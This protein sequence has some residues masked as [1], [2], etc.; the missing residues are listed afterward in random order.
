MTDITNT[1]L[2]VQ[3]DIG[4]DLFGDIAESPAESDD[5]FADW[6]RPEALAANDLFGD[7]PPLLE[8]VVEVAPAPMPD[9]DTAIAFLRSLRP[10]GIHQLVALRP[11]AVEGKKNQECLTV[12]LKGNE[13]H[14]RDFILAWHSKGWGVYYST[15]AVKAG[16]YKKAAKVDV[17]Q[18][19]G[20]YCDIDPEP[21]EGN[22]DPVAH[23]AEERVRLLAKAEAMARDAVAPPTFVVDSGGGIQATWLLDTPVEA[24]PDN[25]VLLEAHGSGLAQKL[26]E[27][28]YCA[29]KVQDVNRLLRLPGSIN[30]PK[31]KKRLQ[32]Q[33]PAL[34]RLLHAGGRRYTVEELALIAPAIDA[35]RLRRASG[36]ASIPAGSASI[37]VLPGLLAK[38][39][40]KYRDERAE[41]IKVLFACKF[42]WGDEAWEAFDEWSSESPNYDLEQNRMTWER[43]HPRGDVHYGSLAY[44]AREGEPVATAGE[45]FE[46]IASPELDMIDAEAES[47]KVPPP[48][49]LPTFAELLERAKAMTSDTSGE[50]RRAL[51]RDAARLDLGSVETDD[52]I[53]AV[54]AATGK[55]VTPLRKE[56]DG[57]RSALRAAHRAEKIEKSG[58]QWWAEWVYVMHD[59]RFHRR[60]GSSVERSAFNLRFGSKVPWEPGQRPPSADEYFCNGHTDLIADEVRYRPGESRFFWEDGKRLFNLYRA[61]GII[62]AA[63][64][65]GPFLRN[66][67]HLFADDPGALEWLLGWVA[68]IMTHPGRKV[69]SAPLLI[70][71]VEGTGK[72][73]FADAMRRVLGEANFFSLRNSTLKQ[74]FNDYLER[75]QLVY[76]AEMMLG[77]NKSVA[78]ELK[79]PIS[80]E[81]VCIRPMHRPAYVAKNVTNF[82]FTSNYLEAAHISRNDRRYFVH[83][84]SAKA[85]DVARRDEYLAWMTDA[86]TPGA[87]LQWAL[88]FRSDFDP[89]APAP[90]TASK[91]DLIE[92]SM[93]HVERLVVGAIADGIG[94]FARALVTTSA[95]IEYAHTKWRK[96]LSPHMAGR[97]LRLAGAV[98]LGQ[99]RLANG[100]KAR[101]WALS[102]ADVWLEASEKAIADELDQASF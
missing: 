67:E 59:N 47:A 23:R 99:K 15:N 75:A 19:Y 86:A 18:L 91:A 89:D 95:V 69:R 94:I 80:D 85:M 45:V 26:R 81:Y 36:S 25:I 1:R 13:A 74:P 100:S 17:T 73:L 40:L 57:E 46:E 11:D 4:A 51:F 90:A 88:D 102:K 27:E 35:G 56:A 66:L 52:I 55:K 3:A 71:E 79:E 2:G 53:A 97:A 62:P 72:G 22:E 33:R 87:L 60:G 14:F 58:A 101:V 93:D 84:S 6:L 10:N 48:P 5:P 30:F 32:G 61:P 21:V 42:E 24:T 37:E 9:P 77:K 63:G 43:E 16:L 96:E 7:L 49:P 65:V 38:L 78:N 83:V 50:L 12:Q 92:E 39:P 28:G 44:W 70:S 20:I 29:D 82:L 68:F 64:N 76:V 98:A 8:P 31:G 41:W 54:A 34:A